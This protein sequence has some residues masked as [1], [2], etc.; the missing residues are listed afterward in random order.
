MLVELY[1]NISDDIIIQETKEQNS[2][3]PNVL[4]RYKEL[5]K[6]IANSVS[7]I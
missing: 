1:G 2:K 5:K 7:L 6:V 4:R 3:L